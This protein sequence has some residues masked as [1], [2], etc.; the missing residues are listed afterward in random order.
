MPPALP[1]LPQVLPT[2]VFG[3]PVDHVPGEDDVADEATSRALAETVR[4]ATARLPEPHRTVVICHYGLFGVEPRGLR[5]IASET[6]L[7]LTTCFRTHRR[8][9]EMLR[10]WV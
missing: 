2:A 1:C 5:H 4:A 3:V 9:L 6:G 10:E 8:A 7:P